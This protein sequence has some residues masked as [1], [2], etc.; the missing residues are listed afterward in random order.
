MS[1]ET[2]TRQRDRDISV[3][4]GIFGSAIISNLNSNRQEVKQLMAPAKR[5]AGFD[6]MGEVGYLSRVDIGMRGAVLQR[7]VATQVAEDLGLVEHVG[8]Y[9][10]TGGRIIDKNSGEGLVEMTARGG[11]VEETEALKKIEAG[12][13]EDGSV[14][15]HFSPRNDSL[16]YKYNCV[17]FWRLI[18]SQVVS[19]R[20]MIKQGEDKM[21]GIYKMLNSGNGLDDSQN[22]LAEPIRSSLKIGQIM[23]G[24]ELTK[25]KSGVSFDQ[26]DSTV[27]QILVGLEGRFGEEVY[28]DPELILRLYTAVHDRLNKVSVPG[29]LISRTELDYY[30]RVAMT[31]KKTI[32]SFGC[33]GSSSV[34]VFRNESVGWII[35]NVDGRYVVEKGSTEGKTFC[36]KCGCWYTEKSCPFCK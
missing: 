15:V 33:S 4:L 7:E 3:L 26:I 13:K 31:G 8:R 18:D 16:G 12:L 30:A 32:S 6:P 9:N 20:L 28:S 34:G 10:L 22:L 24:I 25:D 17:D 23:D 14:W 11:V 19:V 5:V 27:S 35:K 1:R 2:L 29:I 21:R 36:E